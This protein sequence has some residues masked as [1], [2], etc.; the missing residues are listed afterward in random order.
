[1]A[2][3]FSYKCFNKAFF[4]G[5]DANNALCWASEDGHLDIVKY[6]VEH[7]ANIHASNDGLL[8]LASYHRH[9]DI[10]KYLVDQGANIHAN[11]ILSIDS[12]YQKHLI[13]PKI[14]NI[15]MS[16]IIRG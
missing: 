4:S 1:M 13:V 16:G 5:V 15:D 9:L 14:K 6:L 2:L 10:V 3:V 7:G 8:C 12:R 11:N